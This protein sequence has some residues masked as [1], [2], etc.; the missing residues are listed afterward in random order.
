MGILSRIGGLFARNPEVVAEEKMTVEE[1]FRAFEG[2]LSTASGMVVNQHT[3]SSDCACV[4]S[5]PEPG[6]R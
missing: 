1:W 2:Q 3:A 6:R 5:Y 4:R